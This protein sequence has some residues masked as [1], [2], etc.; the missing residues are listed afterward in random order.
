MIKR[1][2]ATKVAAK[3]K[4]KAA[5]IEEPM[6]TNIKFG[7]TG[8]QL[9]MGFIGLT[10]SGRNS[11]WNILSKFGFSEKGHKFARTETKIPVTDYRF[12]KIC[13]I[14]QPSQIV[15]TTLHLLDL[16]NLCEEDGA[17]STTATELGSSLL[18]Q[19]NNVDGY[20][21]IVRAYNQ[22]VESI[23]KDIQI[24]K[25]E[26][27][28]KDMT[29]IERKAANP[30]QAINTARKG[31]KTAD[32]VG[33]EQDQIPKIEEHLMDGSWMTS[34]T[35]DW[36]EIEYIN[37][38]SLL[39]T[40][41]ITY[42]LN[43]DRDAKLS[44]KQKIM[45]EINNWVSE[46]NCTGDVLEFSAK[47]ESFDDLS[48]NTDIIPKIDI[49]NNLIYKGY[50]SLDLQ[51]FFT[52]GTNQV[53]A[54]SLRT[55]TTGPR[56]GAVIHGDFEKAFQSVEVMKCEDLIEF[57]SENALKKQGKFYTE[58]KDYIIEDCDVLNFKIGKKK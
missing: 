55:D 44:E 36:R 3:S 50:Y 20:I 49:I 25:D 5:I 19:M 1:L 42:V 16:A 12:D 15:P 54:W 38:L 22:P 14:Y 39:T 4:G 34:K 56:A 52:A 26:I 23:I 17:E 53:K 35:W 2:F 28:Q 37:T 43:F 32:Q 47:S 48:S 9:K 29:I 51:Q 13:S 10:G 33:F 6:N 8:S 41:P 30:V 58:G 40:R 18:N 46:N 11:I 27:L 57:G 21:Q 45:E 24:V 31:S 7:K